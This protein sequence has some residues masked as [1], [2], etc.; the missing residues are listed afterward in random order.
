[1]NSD[2]FNPNY[3]LDQSMMLGGELSNFLSNSVSNE[4]SNQRH[5][6]LIDN[7]TGMCHGRYFASTP[8]K[9]ADKMYTRMYQVAKINKQILGK[10]IICL[11]EST[12]NSDRK[13]YAFE[14]SRK[15]IYLSND[16]II[17]EIQ[18]PTELCFIKKNK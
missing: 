6:E 4:I 13:I 8:K 2:T 9:A 1:M 15:N 11:K 5:F 10:V 7:D 17:K 3:I 12:K 16:N 14:A 18:V